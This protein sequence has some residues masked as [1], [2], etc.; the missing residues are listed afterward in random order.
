M[1]GHLHAAVTVL[2]SRQIVHSKNITIRGTKMKTLNSMSRMEAMPQ[3]SPIQGQYKQFLN[4]LKNSLGYRR[5][6]FC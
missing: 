2:A 1:Y 4:I 6:S 5:S 3:H